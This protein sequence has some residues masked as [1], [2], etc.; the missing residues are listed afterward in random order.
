[1]LVLRK[2]KVVSYEG[3][4]IP[5]DERITENEESGYEIEI[6]NAEICSKNNL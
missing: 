5:A 2:G 4:E 1:M 3:V 6:E